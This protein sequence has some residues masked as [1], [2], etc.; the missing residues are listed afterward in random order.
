VPNIGAHGRRLRLV[1][2]GVALFLALVGSIRIVVLRLPAIEMFGPG[3]AFLA[4]ALGY[5]QAQGMTCVF[6]AA[7]GGREEDTKGPK[8]YDKEQLARIKAQSTRIILQSLGSAVA[9]TAVFVLLAIW[10]RG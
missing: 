3:L 6:L 1:G 7:S 4:A 9:A 8:K 2:G 5:F 10:R